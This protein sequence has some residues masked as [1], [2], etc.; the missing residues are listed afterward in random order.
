[1]MY[2]K[3]NFTYRVLIM[4]LLDVGVRAPTELINLRV[5]DI[6]GDYEKISIREET[7]KTFGRKPSLTIS[8]RILKEHVSMNGLKPSDYLFNINHASA[9]KY[10][11][12]LAV[13]LFGDIETQ[14]GKKMSKLSLY[15]FR[16]NSC[17]YWV[18]RNKPES[19]L[20]YR[21]GWKSADKIFYYS[22]FL[23]MTDNTSEKDVLT[24]DMRT[25]IENDNDIF[26]RENQ[27][28]KERVKDM[29]DKMGQMQELV[30]SIH[31][32]VIQQPIQVV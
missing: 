11:K 3:A 30:D 24:D 15:D 21:F 22:E 20:K 10:F 2:N 29:E 25:K 1:M 7:S 26:Q 5:S 23:G 18:L 12:R 16:H 14:A 4:F 6:I 19:V 28:L 9:N 13:G 31:K 32:K 17:C 27:I 8:S